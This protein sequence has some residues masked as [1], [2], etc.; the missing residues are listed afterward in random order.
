MLMRDEVFAKE[1]PKL[2]SCF[3]YWLERRLKSFCFRSCLESLYHNDK[4]YMIFKK[5]EEF[6]LERWLSI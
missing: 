6:G 5:E 2:S 4:L 1:K 3:T